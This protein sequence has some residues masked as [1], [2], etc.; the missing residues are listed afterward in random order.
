M[1]APLAL[2]LLSGSPAEAAH[3]SL[4]SRP[5]TYPVDT[6][7]SE[8]P[9]EGFREL[10]VDPYGLKDQLEPA[11]P[12]PLAR[13]KLKPQ[14]VLTKQ[15]VVI[16]DSVHFALDSADIEQDSMP[17][18]D[19][20]AELI[21]ETPG[22][23]KLRVEGH[24]DAQG[25]D[26]YNQQLSEQRAA[27]VVAYLVSQGVDAERLVS[28]GK[29][30]TELALEGDS[31]WVHAENRRVE[32]DIE[33]WDED[34]LAELEAGEVP[35]EE[36]TVVA[37]RFREERMAA[38]KAATPSS[39][40]LPVINETSGWAKVTVNDVEVGVIGP[41][42]NAV[43]KDLPWGRYEVTF[44]NSLG[45]EWTILERTI[46]WD[47][48]PLIPGGKPAQVSVDEGVIPSWYDDPSIGHTSRPERK[49]PASKRPAK[50]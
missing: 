33:T 19:A 42:T 23:L 5:L 32:L 8:G 12:L 22:V 49:G 10:Y 29:G 20:V 14:V 21:N 24:T 2:L 40:A 25:D 15:A 6:N 37:T 36:A 39:G 9:V 7:L 31:P 18:L 16:N 48:E 26:D 17:L 45:Y 47:D 30:E 35:L 43:V 38:R 3:P 41:L 34:V 46:E 50:R 13:V 27:S 28:V 4:P 44:F 1:I 11:K